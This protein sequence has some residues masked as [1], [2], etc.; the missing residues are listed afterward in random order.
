MHANNNSKKLTNDVEQ[1][2][3][4]VYDNKPITKQV[5]NSLIKA[6]TEKNDS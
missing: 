6:I 2:V 4:N 1:L 3:K 5:Y